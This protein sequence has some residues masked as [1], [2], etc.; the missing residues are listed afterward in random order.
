MDQIS[1]ALRG[2]LGPI[3]LPRFHGAVVWRVWSAILSC[4]AVLLKR[5]PCNEPWP[6]CRQN[7]TEHFPKV[8][9]SLPGKPDVPY[10]A[11]ISCS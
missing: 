6:F 10:L 7:Q 2:G 3:S 8:F 5:S 1:F 11:P 4:I 9:V